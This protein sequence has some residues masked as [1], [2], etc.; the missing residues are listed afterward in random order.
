MLTSINSIFYESQSAQCYKLLSYSEHLLAWDSRCP[1]KPCHIL[2]S[3]GLTGACPL[4]YYP[5]G[6]K[7]KY[8]GVRNKIVDN[9]PTGAMYTYK[10]LF[11]QTWTCISFPHVG[12]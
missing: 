6:R 2:L 9:M 11:S 12:I 3:N 8:I 10:F 4:F 1:I 7:E 5:V